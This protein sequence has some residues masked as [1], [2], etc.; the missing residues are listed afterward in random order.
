MQTC[1]QGSIAKHRMKCT[2]GLVPFT[3]ALK[4]CESCVA[5][6]SDHRA[7]CSMEMRC[8]TRISTHSVDEPVDHSRPLMSASTVH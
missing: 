8:F 6:I 3:S 4:I 5:T 1:Q 2:V 7:W